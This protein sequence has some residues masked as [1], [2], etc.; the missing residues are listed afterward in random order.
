[1]KKKITKIESDLSLMIYDLRDQIFI[2]LKNNFDNSIQNVNITISLGRI[3]SID[4][5]YKITLAVFDEI[6]YRQIFDLVEIINIYD[7]ISIAKYF[8]SLKK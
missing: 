2:H 8:E 3:E 7:L 4:V 5:D 1:M 6:G